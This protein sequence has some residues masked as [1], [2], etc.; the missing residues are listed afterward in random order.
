MS[1]LLA[2]ILGVCA[3]FGLWRGRFRGQ[4]LIMVVI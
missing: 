4:N 2:T 3:A 1:T